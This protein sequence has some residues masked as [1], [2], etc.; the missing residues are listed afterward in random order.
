MTAA[1]DPLKNSYIAVSTILLTPVSRG[2]V[3]LRWQP[4]GNSGIDN[5][6]PEIVLNQLKEPID[7]QLMS[8]AVQKSLDVLYSKAWEPYLENPNEKLTSAEEITEILQQ[9]VTTCE[10]LLL[11]QYNKNQCFFVTVWHVGGTCSMQT[12]HTNGV[13]DDKL[14]VQGVRGLRIAGA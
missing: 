10:L 6:V 12:I 4:Y 3:S 14:L 5:D 9:H 1:P 7:R 11:L 8:N 2:I 13:V